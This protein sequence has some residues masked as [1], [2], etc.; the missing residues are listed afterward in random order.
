[1]IDSFGAFFRKETVKMHLKWIMLFLVSNDAKVLF[2]EDLNVTSIPSTTITPTNEFLRSFIE[3][4]YSSFRGYVIYKYNGVQVI[5]YSDNNFLINQELN[6]F[7]VNF[8]LS[9]SNGYTLQTR[10]F[11][12]VEFSSLSAQVTTSTAEHLA[13]NGAVI[14]GGNSNASNEFGA[15]IE[16]SLP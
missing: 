5:A 6:L 3:G 7:S 11:D 13:S 15:Y 16:F 10:T 1:M 4:V 14:N 9:Q 2:Y 12:V 8:S